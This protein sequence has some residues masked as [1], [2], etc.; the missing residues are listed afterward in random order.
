MEL[1]SIDFEEVVTK[2]KRLLKEE[3]G[4]S[5]CFGRRY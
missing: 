4:L 5:P 1:G 2:I 3:P